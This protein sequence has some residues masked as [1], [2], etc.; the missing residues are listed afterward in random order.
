MALGR[1][2]HLFGRQNVP[3]TTAVASPPEGLGGFLLIVRHALTARD[4]FRASMWA[5]RKSSRGSLVVCDR[6]PMPQLRLM[7]GSRIPGLVGGSDDRTSRF[8][9]RIERRYYER[10]PPPDVLVVLMVDPEI[11]VLRKSEEDSGFVRLRSA[12]VWG[13]DWTG[14]GAKIVD[15]G[16]SPDQVLL[17]VK[18]IVW[19]SL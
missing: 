19:S 4:R 9:A 14:S 18:A 16:R 7:D 1:S 6:Y 15:A 2:V 17:D 12:E 11:A 5:R 10:I 3:P 13:S 8:L